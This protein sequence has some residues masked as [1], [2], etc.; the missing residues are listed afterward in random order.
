MGTKCRSSAK[1]RAQSTD[2]HDRTQPPCWGFSELG[3]TSPDPVPSSHPCH[4]CS[5]GC[6]AGLEGKS[7]QL[8]KVTRN[9][10]GGP[11]P[12]EQG[13]AYPRVLGEE[14][15]KTQNK[16]LLSTRRETPKALSGDQNY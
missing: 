6:V 13:K 3:T 8:I 14:P 9:K 7:P 10:F 4:L 15:Q 1:V 5:H 2:G 16:E 12:A 11:S